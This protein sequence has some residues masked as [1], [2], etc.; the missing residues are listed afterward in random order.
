ML[1]EN[2]IS[3][4]IKAESNNDP[5]AVSRPP[6][7]AKGLMQLCDSTG[8]EW[9]GKLVKQDKIPA[10]KEYNPYNPEMNVQIGSAY[11]EY[12][13]HL[14]RSFR[15]GLAAYNWGP[16][17]VKKLIERLG[18]S[19]WCDVEK[20]LPSETYE[21]VR[22]ILSDWRTR[23]SRAGGGQG[24]YDIP[25]LHTLSNEFMAALGETDA[26]FNKEKSMFQKVV[27]WVLSKTPIFKQVNGYKT[28]IGFALF[29]LGVLADVF[30]R[31]AEVFPQ[32]AI[33]GTTA[34]QLGTLAQQ[35]GYALQQVGIGVTVV[36]V[37]HD[38]IKRAS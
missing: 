12:L 22:R 4:V 19:A 35:L 18:T 20:C 36:G 31:A 32:Y 27:N 5:A 21:Y 37:G 34:Q 28:E 11:L 26:V 8:K 13:I 6:I 2:L 23:D 25:Y 17:N 14:F 9:W 38:K 16:G 30:G 10:N 3:S 1:P 15:L 7:Y 24:M 33:L 29:V